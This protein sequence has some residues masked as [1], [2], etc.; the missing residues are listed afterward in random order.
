MRVTLQLDVAPQVDEDALAVER[1]VRAHCL[2]LRQIDLRK[3]LLAFCIPE[4][5]PRGLLGQGADERCKLGAQTNQRLAI[6]RVRSPRKV[7]ILD[8]RED[9]AGGQVPDMQRVVLWAAQ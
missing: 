1:K 6:R 4:H 3:T 5:Q 2:P 8:R 9:L 7:L